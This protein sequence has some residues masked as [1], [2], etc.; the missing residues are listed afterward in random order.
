MARGPHERRQEA[1]HDSQ[2]QHHDPGAAGL[3]YHISLQG[4]P[5]VYNLDRRKDSTSRRTSRRMDDIEDRFSKALRRVSEAVD[6]G[7]AYKLDRR[8]DSASG[9]MEDI[10]YR[11]SK[12][13]RRVTEAADDGMSDYIKARDDSNRRR[14]DGWFVDIFENIAKGV[15]KAVSEASP[16]LVDVTEAYSSR[17]NRRLMRDILETAPRLPIIGRMVEDDDDDDDDDD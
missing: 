17:P 4:R 9:R 11:F 6:D 15:S 14:K 10:E 2:E 12:A 13:L 7:R 8:R 3:G 5:R 16:A 1:Q